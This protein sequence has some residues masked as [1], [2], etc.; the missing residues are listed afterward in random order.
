MQFA[1]KTGPQREA[2]YRPYSE[3]GEAI[4]VWALVPTL[5]ELT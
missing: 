2:L 4:S 3:N 5:F 1:V